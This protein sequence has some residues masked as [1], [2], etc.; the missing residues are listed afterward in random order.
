MECMH[1]AGFSC[2]FFETGICFWKRK[3]MHMKNR[4]YISLVVVLVMMLAI[5]MTGMASAVDVCG[6][7]IRDHIVPEAVARMSC[8]A[9]GDITYARC[10]GVH[11]YDHVDMHRPGNQFCM[12][13]WYVSTHEHVCLSCGYVVGSGTHLCLVVHELCADESWCIDG[14]I[15]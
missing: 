9:C 1:N 15:M 6:D 5:G 11:T 12:R 2:M 3:G 7:D 10:T 4:R 14:V 8:T 13:A